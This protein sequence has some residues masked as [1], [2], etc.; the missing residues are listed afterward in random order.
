MSPWHHPTPPNGYGLLSWRRAAPRCSRAT[1]RRK[2][3]YYARAGFH[4]G[5]FCE[6][7]MFFFSGRA[8]QALLQ[9]LPLGDALHNTTIDKSATSSSWCA[10]PT[11][12]G[13]CR[14]RPGVMKKRRRA[15]CPRLPGPPSC[16]GPSA[17][18]SPQRT[19]KTLSVGEV[20]ASPRSARTS[21]RD[22][23]ASPGCGS[24]T[25]GGDTEDAS[26]SATRSFADVRRGHSL[27]RRS[28]RSSC[29]AD[30]IRLHIFAIRY[31][32]RRRP[33]CPTAS[34]PIWVA[35]SHLP[36]AHAA[37]ARWRDCRSALRPAQR[38]PTAC[39]SRLRI[40]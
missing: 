25:S 16:T 12:R 24:G 23:K 39:S 3:D 26:S 17:W 31:P 2:P 36:A 10:P 29:D 21:R 35:R 28:A 1:L 22:G 19:G 38:S 37:P 6:R 32:W 7:G 5:R 9:H 4:R 13:P 11:T 33:D 34:S 40:V 15:V 14:H 8:C 20:V 27:K 18:S 30:M